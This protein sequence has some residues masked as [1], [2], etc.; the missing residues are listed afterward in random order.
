MEGS[1]IKAYGGFYYVRDDDRTWELR[2]RGRLRRAA[3]TTCPQAGVRQ[4]RPSD[5]PEA[6]VVGRRRPVHITG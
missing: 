1:L 3:L 4:A 6:L 5:R 2:A